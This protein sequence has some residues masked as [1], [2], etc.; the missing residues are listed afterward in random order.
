MRTPKLVAAFGLL[1]GLLPGVGRADEAVKNLSLTAYVASGSRAER[2]EYDG[3][4]RTLTVITPSSRKGTGESRRRRQLDDAAVAAIER[5]AEQ[6]GLAT[7]TPPEATGASRT[8]I[9]LTIDERTVT[10]EPSWF[11]A[12]K[13]RLQPLVST[14]EDLAYP[15]GRD[16]LPL[17][18]TQSQ[19]P[20]REPAATPTAAPAT[21]PALPAAIDGFSKKLGEAVR[22][23]RRVS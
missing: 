2:F 8:R 13:D 1:L 11:F 19:A 16:G 22:K 3:R 4:A 6:A 12:N 18:S 9:E 10:A 7:L 14:L 15:H 5:A 23:P 20:A 17:P 21:A